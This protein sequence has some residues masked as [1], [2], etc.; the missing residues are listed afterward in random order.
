MRLF[1][2]IRSNMG[3][4]G[5]SYIGSATAPLIPQTIPLGQEMWINYKIQV[6]FTSDKGDSTSAC[7]IHPTLFPLELYKSNNI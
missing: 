6:I 5:Q 1:V 4:R 2:C 3:K 7:T